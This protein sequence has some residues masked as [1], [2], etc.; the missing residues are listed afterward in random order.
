MV[1]RI[2]GGRMYLW[3]AGDDESQVLDVL[4]QQRLNKD[5]AQIFLRGC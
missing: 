5:V 4:V 2:G 3:R 1:C